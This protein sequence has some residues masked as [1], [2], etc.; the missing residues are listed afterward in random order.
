MT[1]LSTNNLRD[2]FKVVIVERCPLP[3]GL[4][5]FPYEYFCSY[6]SKSNSSSRCYFTTEDVL[7]ISY[8][9]IFEFHQYFL[10]KSIMKFCLDKFRSRLRLV[11]VISDSLVCMWSSDCFVY[12]QFSVFPLSRLFFFLFCFSFVYFSLVFFSRVYSISNWFLLYFFQCYSLRILLSLQYARYNNQTS[13]H[14]HVELWLHEKIMVNLSKFL[15]RRDC[16]LQTRPKESVHIG[17][18]YCIL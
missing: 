4:N 11:I 2:R 16:L 5:S 15:L 14:I 8:W 13:A 17:R 18:F 10:Q 9:K 7:R 3:R 12:N 1:L 6:R